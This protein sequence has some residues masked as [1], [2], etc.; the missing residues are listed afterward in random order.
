M[1]IHTFPSRAATSVKNAVSWVVENTVENAWI[2]SCGMFAIGKNPRNFHA[3]FHAGFHTHP[4][5]TFH[6][7]I[8][9]RLRQPCLAEGAHPR[10][11]LLAQRSDLADPGQ[12]PGHI[13]KL[14]ALVKSVTDH[15]TNVSMYTALDAIQITPSALCST[16]C[17]AV[18]CPCARSWLLRISVRPLD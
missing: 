7:L 5:P 2:F 16:A 14:L 9:P 3:D 12:G 8:A 1:R 10:Q 18:Y 6:H 15:L 11:R 17:L 4:G 13:P